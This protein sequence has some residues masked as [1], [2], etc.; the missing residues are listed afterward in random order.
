M[1]YIAIE[2]ASFSIHLAQY[3]ASIHEGTSHAQRIGYCLLQNVS[4]GVHVSISSITAR[5]LMGTF[6]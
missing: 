6:I 1:N 5:T 4:C 2:M 3:P